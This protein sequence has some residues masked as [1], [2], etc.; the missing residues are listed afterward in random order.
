MNVTQEMEYFLDQLVDTHVVG[1]PFT[2]WLRIFKHNKVKTTS[3]LQYLKELKEIL[4]TIPKKI[5]A[6]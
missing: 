5:L 4:D 6:R 1:Q 3:S 2:T